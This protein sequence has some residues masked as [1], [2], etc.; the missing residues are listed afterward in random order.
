MLALVCAVLVLELWDAPLHTPW[1]YSGDGVH[2]GMFVKGI[3]DHG[4]HYTNPSL[5]APEGQQL[6]DWPIASGENLQA[7][8]VKLLGFVSSDWAAV[9][10]VYFLLTFP[11][12]ALTAFA[13][14][15]A[16]GSARGPAIVCSALFALAPYHF[17][18][19]E[20]ELFIVGYFAVPLAAYLVLR[21]LADDALFARRDSP[22]RVLAYA[23]SRTL[24][25]VALCL[26]IVLASGSFYYSAFTSSS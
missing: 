4:W 12:A 3:L 19:G 18:R 21:I 10:N 2:Y 24:L 25:T 23:S 22:S 9:M 7:L 16:L 15:R 14:L 17:V 5:G 8:V 13:V 1:S 11:L 20:R 26:T 6:Y